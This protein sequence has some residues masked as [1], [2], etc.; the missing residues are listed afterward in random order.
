MTITAVVTIIV[1][2]EHLERLIE[3]LQMPGQV[4]KIY[5]IPS[6]G[7]GSSSSGS[8]PLPL[9]CRI[10]SDISSDNLGSCTKPLCKK[11]VLP[12]LFAK[13]VI[14][15]WSLVFLLLLHNM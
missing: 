15:Q 5:Y 1:V 14:T 3:K 2:L 13:T 9:S 7:M 8:L 4:H 11:K 6:I 10:T 12:L